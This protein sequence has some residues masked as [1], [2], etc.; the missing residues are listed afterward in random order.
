MR[1]LERKLEILV[2][3]DGREEC[4]IYEQR[5]KLGGKCPGEKLVK[6]DQTQR[7]KGWKEG[8]RNNVYNNNNIE[9]TELRDN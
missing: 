5:H 6:A 1:I 4:P 3:I 8:H 7:Q 9:A 2:R